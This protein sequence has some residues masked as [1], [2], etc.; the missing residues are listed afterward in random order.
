MAHEL[1]LEQMNELLYI[2]GFKPPL[3]TRKVLVPKDVPEWA[4]VLFSQMYIQSKHYDSAIASFEQLMT[5]WLS[6]ASTIQEI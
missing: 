3:Q 6:G 2:A 1:S 4:I 5:K